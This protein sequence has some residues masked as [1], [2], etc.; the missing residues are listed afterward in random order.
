MFRNHI[1][2]S[3]LASI[4][5]ILSVALSNCS[6]QPDDPSLQVR[7]AWSRPGTE[8][9]A[10]GAFY[11]TVKNEGGAGD[12][13]LGGTSPAC[14]ALELHQTVE[15][16]QGAMGMRPVEGGLDIPPGSEVKLEPGGY[17]FMCINPTDVFEGGDTFPLALKFDVSGSR[18]IEVEVRTGG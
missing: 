15:T 1:N 6:S 5:F 13:L 3:Y 7:D 4:G 10:R 18:Q 16:D 2:W 14:E 17:H 12:T 9:V 11:L 8:L